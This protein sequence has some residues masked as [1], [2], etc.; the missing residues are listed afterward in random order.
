MQASL[1]PV[2]EHPMAVAAS[3][4]FQRSAR[5]RTQRASSS[6][7]WGYSSLSIMFLST[8]SAINRAACGSIHVVTKVARFS[9][10]LPSSNSSSWTI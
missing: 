5:M 7:V 6:A 2:V 9:L 8:H 1:E 3:G 4:A 10:A